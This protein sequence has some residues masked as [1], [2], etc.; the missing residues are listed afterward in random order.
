LT[1]FWGTL[2]FGYKA[3]TVGAI[4]VSG[5]LVYTYRDFLVHLFHKLVEKT[6][7]EGL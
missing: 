3:A 2:G 5:Y 1:T 6:K 7:E 4:I